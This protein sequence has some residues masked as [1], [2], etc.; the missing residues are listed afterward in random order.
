M[1]RILQWL[2][3]EFNLLPHVSRPFQPHGDDLKWL[4]GK[5]ETVRGGFQGRLFSLQRVT[6]PCRLYVH[7]GSL[8]VHRVRLAA[9]FQEAQN[10]SVAVLGPFQVTRTTLGWSTCTKLPWA[11]SSGRGV[12]RALSCDVIW[13]TSAGVISSH[14]KRLRRALSRRSRWSAHSET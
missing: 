7:P 14:P 2:R 6:A 12:S 1:V 11:A 9:D 4:D 3:A 10:G 5:A 8:H 13:S